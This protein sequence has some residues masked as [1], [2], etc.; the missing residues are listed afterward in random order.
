MLFFIFS[1]PLYI[2]FAIVN[3]EK[4]GKSSR[5]ETESQ[6]YSGN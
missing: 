1:K 6:D 5:V 3:Y 2:S 4:S